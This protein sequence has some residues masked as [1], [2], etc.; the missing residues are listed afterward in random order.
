MRELHEDGNCEQVLALIGVGAKII[1]YQRMLRTPR[2]TE[3]N[4]MPVSGWHFHPKF[5]YRLG[6]KSLMP[7]AKTIKKRRCPD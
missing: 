1:H 5:V 3:K 4:W 7:T 2:Q 6:E